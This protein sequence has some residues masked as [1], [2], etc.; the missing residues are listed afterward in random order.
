[1]RK[2]WLI[3]FPTAP[4]GAYAYQKAVPLVLA[5]YYLLPYIDVGVRIGA[6]MDG[7]IDQIDAVVHYVQPGGSSLLS[8]Q[9]YRASQ[10]A[11]DALRRANPALYAERQREKYIMGPKR[12]HRPW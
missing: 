4:V 8:R 1:V 3:G 11:A 6:L 12:R 10:V 2:P 5:T 7:T 9:A